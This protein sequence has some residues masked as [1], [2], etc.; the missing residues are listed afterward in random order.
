[1]DHLFPMENAP[2]AN[3]ISLSISIGLPMGRQT[4]ITIFGKV[5]EFVLFLNLIITT[6]GWELKYYSSRDTIDSV[7]GLTWSIFLNKEE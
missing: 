5:E 2:T 1:M 3:S 4:T 6:F 7:I